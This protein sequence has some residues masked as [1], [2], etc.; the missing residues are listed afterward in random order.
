MMCDFP[1]FAAAVADVQRGG[2]RHAGVVHGANSTILSVLYGLILKP[3]PF[4]DAGQ[5][6]DVY[7][8]D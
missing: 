1:A 2:G 6:V 4:P 7:T 3:L 8:C 5:I